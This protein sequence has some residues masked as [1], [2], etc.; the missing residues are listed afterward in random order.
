MKK[1]VI[2][3]EGHVQ[4]LSN[5]RALGEAGIPVYV[6]DTTNCIAK[7]SRYCSKFFLCP[8]FL[9]DSFAEFMIDLA[10]RESL[11]GW[12]LFP[13]NDH[14]VYSITKHRDKMTQF[15]KILT[16]SS[17][18]IERI[19]DKSLLIETAK[20]AGIPIPETQLFLTPDDI[21]SDTLHFPVITKG[22]NGL[23][24]Y[25][26]TKKK[27]FFAANETELRQQLNTISSKIPLDKT[28]TQEVIPQS[29]EYKTISCTVFCI[30]GIV[31]ACWIGEKVR[32]HPLTFGTATAAKSI[33]QETCKTQTIQLIQA[34]QFSG[35]CE[36]EFVH[37]PRDQQFKLIEINPRTWLWVGLAKAC[38]VNF[39]LMAWKYVNGIEQE[40]PMN[41][42]KDV[43]WVNPFTDSVF[44]FLAILKGKLNLASYLKNRF[45]EKSVS[46]LFYSSDQ[47]PAWMYFL[48]IFSFLRKR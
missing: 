31:K 5:T 28:F 3:I 47:K 9:S 45:N 13:S 6:V 32:E 33:E 22:R 29:K 44:S 25:K 15:Y 38:G 43:V 4:G 48:M 34:L 35:I 27:A 26:A 42:Q 11:Q 20:T 19:Y 17:E 16:P 2:I 39:A 10:E 12:L 46:A 18:I 7:Y 21:P 36:V 14:A 24:F 23:S 37:D 8:D 30:E 41:Y 1:G 40:Y